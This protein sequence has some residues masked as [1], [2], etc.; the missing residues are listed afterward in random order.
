[1]SLL[2]SPTA[3]ATLPRVGSPPLFADEPSGAPRQS[4][5]LRLLRIHSWSIDLKTER[6]RW[7]SVDAND[8]TVVIKATLTDLLKQANDEDA[9]KFRAHLK[10]A[11]D[12]GSAGP[13]HFRFDDL[14]HAASEI[15]SVCVLKWLAGHP[16]VVGLYR[17]CEKEQRQA[18]VVGAMRA[19]IETLV[20]ESTSCMVVLARDGTIL[21]C[22]APFAKCL[23]LK[24]RRMAIRQNALDLV[25]GLSERLEGIIRG[26]LL[27]QEALSGHFVTT[28]PGGQ[29][30]GV[31]WKAFGLDLQRGESATRVFAFDLRRTEADDII[32]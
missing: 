6:V 7:E 12:T 16:V 23:N 29:V 11:I 18:A 2:V 32:D 30:R 24:D 15:E 20:A 31:R 3:P 13:D 8:R 4:E 17:N 9:G 10:Q 14:D 5:L 25:G 26:A 1:M 28:F 27:S 22:N 19:T 21:N